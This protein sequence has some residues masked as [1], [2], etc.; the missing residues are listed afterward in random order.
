MEFLLQT[1][2]FIYFVPNI[3]D[4]LIWLLSQQ[5]IGVLYVLHETH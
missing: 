1:L 4:P 2:Y 5:L 3:T